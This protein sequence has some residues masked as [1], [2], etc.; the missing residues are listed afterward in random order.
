ATSA[1]ASTVA[2]TGAAGRVSLADTLGD[3][4]YWLV[5]LLLLPAILGTLALE[6]ILAPVQNLLNEVFG[7]LPNI[8]AAILIG[9]IGWFVARIIRKIDTS[10]LAAAGVDR[11]GERV[12]LSGVMGGQTLSG[13]IGLVV[14][15]FILVPVMISALNALDIAAITGPATNMLNTFMAAIPNI[16]AAAVVLAISFVVGRLVAGLVSSL[17]AGIGFNS[18]PARLGLGRAATAGTRPPSDVVGSL[19]LVAVMLFAAIEAARLLGFEALA[20]LM[21]GFIVLGGQIVLGLIVF[22]IG[23]YLANLAAGIVASSGVAQAGLL[24]LLTRV[25]IMVLAGAMALNQMGL[26]EEIV[27]LAFGLLL[28]A[29]AVAAALAFGLGGR[30]AAGRQLE[31]WVQ[32]VKSDQPVVSESTAMAGTGSVGSGSMGTPPVGV[33]PTGMPP[34]RTDERPPRPPMA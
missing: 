14:Y 3:V 30:E 11:L 27:N 6:G 16:F 21:A 18:L 25:A 13:L 5:W 33:T 2:E 10:L 32:R 31:Q 28:G 12:G 24:A 34:Q 9:V 20:N 29:V 22:A 1:A 23:L 26:A 19:V 4:V 8:F 15:V 7:Y 17:L